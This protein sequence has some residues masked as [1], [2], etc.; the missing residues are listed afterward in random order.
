MYYGTKEFPAGKIMGHPHECLSKSYCVGLRMQHERS[1]GGYRLHFEG[2]SMSVVDC[3]SG[4]ICSCDYVYNGVIFCKA[5]RRGSGI[6][7]VC[8]N[9]ISEVYGLM[10]TDDE[11]K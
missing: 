7:M 4:Y 2:P 10:E 6:R 8:A 5:C 11:K 9:E 1:G 3:G